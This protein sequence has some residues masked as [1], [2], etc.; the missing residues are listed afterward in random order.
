MGDTAKTPLYGA[1]EGLDFKKVGAPVS[2]N[3]TPVESRDP[4]FPGVLVLA[5]APEHAP[6][7]DFSGATGVFTLNHVVLVMGNV[8]NERTD[9]DVEDGS[10][11]GLWVRHADSTGF[12]GTWDNWGIVVAGN[13]YY[14]A[15]R[16]GPTPPRP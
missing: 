9:L 16:V 1:A 5:H 15:V 2:D 14:C 13:G 7:P 3:G 6:E 11:I 4:V 12:S 10:G 8:S